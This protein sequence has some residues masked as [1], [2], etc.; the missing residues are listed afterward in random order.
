[1]CMG[2]MYKPSYDNG[3]VGALVEVVAARARVRQQVGQVA[4][5]VDHDP[6]GARAGAA[7]E[8]LAAGQDGELVP[9]AGS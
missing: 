4:V 2:L 1:M 6:V 5:G 7:I 8:D 9:R 3:S